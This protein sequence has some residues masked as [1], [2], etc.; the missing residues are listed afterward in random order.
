MCIHYKYYKSS[1][2]GGLILHLG[3]GYS[4]CFDYYQNLFIVYTL[5]IVSTLFIVFFI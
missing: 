4:L 5:I 2:F 3:L 1:L